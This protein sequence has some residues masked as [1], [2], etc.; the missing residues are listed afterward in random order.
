MY[1][2]ATVIATH[3]SLV[4][5]PKPVYVTLDSKCQLAHEPH[6][7]TIGEQIIGAG[8]AVL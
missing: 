2:A 3:S 1:G 6:F 7:S 4:R 5:G 8:T